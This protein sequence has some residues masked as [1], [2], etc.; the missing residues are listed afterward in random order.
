MIHSDI[1]FY[2]ILRFKTKATHYLKM[3]VI[4]DNFVGQ[5]MVRRSDINQNI[6]N[7]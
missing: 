7:Q 6:L 5:L 2:L 3:S 4:L 1:V